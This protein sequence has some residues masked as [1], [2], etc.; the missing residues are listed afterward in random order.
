[1]KHH[2]VH[3]STKKRALKVFLWPLIVEERVMQLK[4][5]PKKECLK[6]ILPFFNE[7]NLRKQLEKYQ[8]LKNKRK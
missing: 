1:M 3:Q 6:M 7:L 8:D 5:L 2:P 4:L